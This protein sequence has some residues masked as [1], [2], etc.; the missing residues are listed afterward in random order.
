MNPARLE[1]AIGQYEEVIEIQRQKKDWKMWSELNRELN[2]LKGLHSEKIEIK[3]KLDHNI[4]SVEV[5][6]I[7]EQ[8]KPNVDNE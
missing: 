2:K 4:T 8:K 3:G 6:I 5:N 7:T 1:E